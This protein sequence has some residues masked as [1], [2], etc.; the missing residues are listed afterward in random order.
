MPQAFATTDRPYKTHSRWVPGV[1]SVK[2]PAD[3]SDTEIAWGENIVN[4][5]GILQTRPGY[6]IRAS[7]AGERL[8]GVCVFTPRNSTPRLVAAVDG[9]VYTAEY[10]GYNFTQIPGLSFAS[11]ARFV[12]MEPTIRS[13]KRNGDGS[14]SLI[15][16][17]P[18][19]CLADGS[20]RMG[21]WDGTTGQHKGPDAPDYGPP[22][23]C[24]WMEWLGGRLWAAYGNRVKVSDIVDPMT[25][26]EGTYLAERDNFDLPDTCTGLIKTS[27]DTG[28]L[29][30]TADDTT[31]FRANI[32]D[33]AE[34]AL[35]PDFQK[36]I[37]PGIGCVAGRS[38]V[39]AYGE[40]YWF[41]KGGLISLNAALNSQQSSTIDVIDQAMM[42]SKRGLCADLA[43][44]A[45]VS[46]ENYLLMSVPYADLYNAHTW[47]LDKQPLNGRR[48]QA[49][50]GVWTGVRPVQWAEGYIGGQN[51]CFFGSYDKSPFNDT[52]IHIWE[53]F[54][55]SREDEGGQIGCQVEFAPIRNDDVMEFRYAEAEIVELLGDVNLQAFIGGL[56][57]AWHAAGEADYQAQKGSIGGPYQQT[58]N[59]SSILQA[60][61][62]QSREFRT[63]E[64]TSQ[65]TSSGPESRYV[66][67]R[68]KAFSL[69]LEWRGRIGIREVRYFVTTQ[70]PKDL[71]GAIGADERGEVNAV[72]ER[73]ETI[74]E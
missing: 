44:V 72:T 58:L 38:L 34:W 48:E 59:T 43:G 64:F 66:A 39:N 2:H 61:R 26:S 42:R 27:N 47:V 35:T 11:T 52:R 53:A 31:A 25:F 40:T 7:I 16:P 8:Q 36:V 17:T 62:P 33:R 32:Q 12:Q 14:I 49:W 19:L 22:A 4:R 10:P 57:G 41:T 74:T 29:A 50:N 6:R 65:E 54:H 23:G 15:A 63:E 1:N 30:F 56:K 71:K 9:R 3:L 18:M 13:A 21:Y 69:L 28:I 37:I 51:R 24:L 5:G 70:A 73:G 20:G 55:Q 68:D 46:F 45:G 67:G 60:Y